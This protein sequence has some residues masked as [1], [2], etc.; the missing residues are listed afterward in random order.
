MEIVDR[1]YKSLNPN[2]LRPSVQTVDKEKKSEREMR[3]PNKGR[4]SFVW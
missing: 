3:T 1:E 2:Q 4:D